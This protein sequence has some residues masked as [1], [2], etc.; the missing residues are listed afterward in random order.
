MGGS[1]RRDEMVGMAQWAVIIPAELW[2]SERLFH[3]DSVRLP[4]TG[5]EI[6]DDILLVVGDPTLGSDASGP[7]TDDAP[8]ADGGEAHAVGGARAVAVG[9]ARDTR[10]GTLLVAYTKRA[11]DR[12]VSADDLKLAE[13]VTALDAGAFA[14]IAD[15][16]TDD[17]QGARRQTW[18]V[19]VD[20]P[21]EA[22]SPAEAVRQFWSYVAELGPAELPAFVSPAGN[23][24][25]MQAFVLGAEANLD[26]EEDED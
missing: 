3:H 26:P 6:G 14:G 18:L 21:I 22:A 10:R 4:A 25:A 19:S 5:P 12:P 9:T 24:L 17:D 8:G 23:E 16:L 13:T 1:R 15:R 20:L 11:F 2:A 7:A